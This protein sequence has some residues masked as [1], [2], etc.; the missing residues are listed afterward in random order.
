MIKRGSADTPA[1]QTTLLEFIRQLIDLLTIRESVAPMK[2]QKASS[3]SLKENNFPSALVTPL[4][5]GNFVFTLNWL[6]LPC[7]ARSQP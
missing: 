2:L 5:F 3:T 6:Y 1:S 4:P 7:I